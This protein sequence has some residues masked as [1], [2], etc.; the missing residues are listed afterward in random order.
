MMS[1][2]VRV[3]LNYDRWTRE[4]SSG[5]VTVN[6]WGTHVFS[7]EDSRGSPERESIKA[8]FFL[9]EASATLEWG[10]LEGKHRSTTSFTSSP[11]SS[12]LECTRS[13]E[14]DPVMFTVHNFYSQYS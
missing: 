12:E 1:E 14:S 9:S 2:N 7:E 4:T 5:G 3:Y 13:C 11:W 6:D 8:L 10:D